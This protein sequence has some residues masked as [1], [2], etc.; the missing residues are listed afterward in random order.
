VIVGADPNPMLN[1][2]AP[3][4]TQHPPRSPRVQLGGFVHLPRLLDKARATI[5]GKNGEYK[6]N[7]PLDQN[8][9]K[10]TGIDADAFL[11]EVRKGGSDTQVLAWVRERSARFPSDIAA[12]DAWMRG[13]APGGVGGHAWF[14]ELIKANAPDR[15]D[16]FGFFDLL[17][18][19][20]YVSF[21]G[22]P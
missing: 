8:F 18:M 20:D 6:Y 11:A 3:D 14:S 7:C 1:L 13:N 22:K 9:F 2:A 19:D 5:S 16:I 10:F 15:Q 17:D 21:G 4:L 12:W